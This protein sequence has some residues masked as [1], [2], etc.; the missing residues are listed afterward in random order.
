MANPEQG[1]LIQT[2]VTI[3]SSIFSHLSPS[4]IAVRNIIPINFIK[5]NDSRRNSFQIADS[6]LPFQEEGQFALHGFT[7]C[8]LNM[9]VESA[10][11]LA[12]HVCDHHHGESVPK[13]QLGFTTLFCQAPFPAKVSEVTLQVRL[14]HTVRELGSKT[15]HQIVSDL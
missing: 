5:L 1:T 12:A 15:R 11:F 13:K 2:V 7:A 9:L 8:F 14:F 10:S 6:S 3:R 4:H